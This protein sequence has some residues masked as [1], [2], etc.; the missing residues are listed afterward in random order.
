MKERLLDILHWLKKPDTQ[1]LDISNAQKLR[2]LFQLVII[3]ALMVLPFFAM[4]YFIHYYV[5]KLLGPIETLNMAGLLFLGVLV[6]P[7]VEELLFRFPLT[8]KRN[9]LARGLDYFLGG[10]IERNWPS[11]FKYFMYTM[12]FLFGIMHL[13]NYDNREV[14]FFALGPL[15][16]GSQLLGGLV[17]S[18]SRIK[19]G[20]V[21][22]FLQHAI[23]N[24]TIFAVMLSVYQNES[25]IDLNAEEYSLKVN[26]FYCPDEFA[27]SFDFDIS[28]DTIYHIKSYQ[29]AF[30]GVFE[31]LGMDSVVAYD[32]FIMDMEFESEKGM[33]KSEFVKLLEEYIEFEN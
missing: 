5:L 14:L 1:A 33:H 11:F 7:F 29:Y 10:K 23:Y 13:W 21:W 4:A 30:N 8:Y 25:I 27:Y 17:L 26:G 3:D 9:Y 24:L 31:T 22:S 12:A 6:V 18:Y 32:D 2:V 20:F 28:N 16:T 19:L 15:I